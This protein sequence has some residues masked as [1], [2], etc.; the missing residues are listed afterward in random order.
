MAHRCFLC[1]SRGHTSS[2]CRKKGRV[3]CT[4]FRRPHHHSF[5]DEAITNTSVGDRN[6]VT[7]VVVVDVDNSAFTYL[8]KAR[9]RITGPT[10]L[11]RITRC[12]LDGGSQSCF[13]TDTSIE[14]LK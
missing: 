11:S 4:R 5:C 8:Q 2:N 3:Q 10:V 6:N 12:V 13:I 7:V 1:L 14:E 9:V